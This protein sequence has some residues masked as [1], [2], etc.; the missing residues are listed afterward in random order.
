MRHLIPLLG[1]LLLSAACAE[2]RHPTD[3]GSAAAH[4]ATALAAVSGLSSRWDT[5]DADIRAETV[6]RRAAGD[7]APSVRTVSYHVR[8][9]RGEGGWTTT[10]SMP[11]AS[12]GRLPTGDRGS[13]LPSGPSRIEYDAHGNAR[14]FAADGREIGSSTLEERMA[15]MRPDVRA[16]LTAEP[17]SGAGGP[18]PVGGG[19]SALEQSLV[20][21]D[22]YVVVREQLMR[23]FTP[24]GGTTSGHETFA[25]QL[26]DTVVTITADPAIGGI[27]GVELTAF[28]RRQ[29]RMHLEY[30][31]LSDGSYFR[32]RTRVEMAGNGGAA[33]RTV[34]ITL[35]NISLSRAGGVDAARSR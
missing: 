1:A 31:P 33:G 21:P 23:A 18:A 6:E 35:T 11:A 14:A 16:R 13:T 26:G 28:G 32:S 7:L 24:A 5:F 9:A 12:S 30:A 19:A 15:H 3:Q 10:I 22:R 34:E 20:S 4:A 27:T 2:D 8:R 29:V 25:R 17:A